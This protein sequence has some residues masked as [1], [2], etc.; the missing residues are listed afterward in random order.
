MFHINNSCRYGAY[1]RV[2]HG[3]PCDVCKRN[4]I[5]PLAFDPESG[6][7]DYFCPL[8]LRE[9]GEGGSFVFCG[10]FGYKAN[11]FAAHIGPCLGAHVI[12]RAKTSECNICFENTI[13]LGRQFGLLSSC[14]PSLIFLCRSLPPIVQMGAITYFVL[15]AFA[16][17]GPQLTV[18]EKLSVLAPSV[19]LSRIL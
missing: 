16:I 17:G 2:T 7:V 15:N 8:F 18:L 5:H 13:S 1:C 3:L 11:N 19:A 6:F 14:Y 4:V 12:S 10:F 9:L